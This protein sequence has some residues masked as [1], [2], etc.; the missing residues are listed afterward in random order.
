MDD[1]GR[2]QLLEHVSVL[3]EQQAE[4][5]A[6]VVRDQVEF[7]PVLVPRRLDRL[8]ARVESDDLA[9]GEEVAA[10]QVVIRIRRR[11]AVQM[12]R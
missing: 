11:E 8:T 5:L 3:L 2:V 4:E 7:K 10:S 12:R 6:G 9:G 1:Q